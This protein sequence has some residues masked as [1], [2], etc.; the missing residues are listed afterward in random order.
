VAVLAIALIVILVRPVIECDTVLE[1]ENLRPLISKSG[2]CDEKN[3]R[4]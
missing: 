4:S 1:L 2:Y 3:C